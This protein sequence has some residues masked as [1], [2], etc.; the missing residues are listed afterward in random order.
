[1]GELLK[2]QEAAEKLGVSKTEIKFFI[3]NKKLDGVSSGKN[4]YITRSSLNK[5]IGGDT[6][7]TEKNNYG[8]PQSEELESLLPTMG[9]DSDKGGAKVKKKYTGNVYKL[10]D[11]RYM[12]QIN[13]GTDKNGKRDR[14]SK[15]FKDIA[16][17]KIDL[18][19]KL[20]ELNNPKPKETEAAFVGGDYE[21]LV[22]EIRRA[23]RKELQE[24]AERNYTKLTF[25]Q[26]AIR[27][28]QEGIGKGNS[29]TIEGYRRGLRYICPYIGDMA[30]TMITKADLN[31]AFQKIAM[32]YAD[33]NIK[34]ANVIVRYIFR[35]AYDKGEI[36]K[37]VLYDFKCPNSRKPVPIKKKFYTDDEVK[38]ILEKSK[39]YSQ[40]LYT[41][42]CILECTGLRPAELFALTW[43]AIDFK[44]K[45]VSVFQAVSRD[46]DEVTDIYKSPKSREFI[47]TTKNTVQRV[48]PLSALAL[49]ALSE[50]KTS[51]QNNKNE[52]IRNSI[53]VFPNPEGRW[54]ESTAQNRCANRFRKKYGLEDI[55]VTFYKFRHTMCTR[56]AVNKYP[57]SVAKLILGDNDDKV[58]N[59]V[60]THVREMQA[61]DIAKDFY[62]SLDKKH[63]AFG[64]MFGQ[65]VGN[66]TSAQQ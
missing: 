20:E 63:E 37:N 43:G 11:G 6:T 49:E 53:Y 44:S 34:R 32:E 7:E 54:L 55:G 50:W 61:K 1:M 24:E 18:Q 57:T 8:Y 12:V 65:Q 51:C 29:R 26:Y 66:E 62:E 35:T 4:T 16:S 17:A 31:K 13:K 25:E 9:N 59:D 38:L 56:L 21:Q 45:T 5:L 42:F 48:L 39:K 60:Y 40:C 27:C 19:E 41:M 47:A 3:Q 2:M 14:Y 46:F 23:V 22:E 36:P 58:V 15:S 64:L 10:K 52:R 30:M 33:S 28:L